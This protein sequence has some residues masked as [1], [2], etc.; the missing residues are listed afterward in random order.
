MPLVLPGNRRSRR[1]EAV[2][3]EPNYLERSGALCVEVW[4]SARLS[5]ARFLPTGNREKWKAMMFFSE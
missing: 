4:R 2:V 5:V 3:T 1:G